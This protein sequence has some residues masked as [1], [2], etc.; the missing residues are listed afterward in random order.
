[1]SASISS[2]RLPSCAKLMASASAVVDLPS[3]AT[4][5]VTIRRRGAPSAVENC[6]D[7]RMER[8]ASANDPR[9]SSTASKASSCSTRLLFLTFGMMPS[10]GTPNC[11]SSSSAC[12]I[13]SSMCSRRKIR[14]RPS[15]RPTAT[16]M[17]AFTD[18]SGLNGNSGALATSTTEMLLAATP[19]VTPTSFR[20]CNRLS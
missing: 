6:S 9:G 5:L 2:T 15:I 13:E 10:K 14:P 3:L 17:A 8:Y 12:L 16:P 7:V 20:R 19:L 11:G 18:M 4:L 1:M